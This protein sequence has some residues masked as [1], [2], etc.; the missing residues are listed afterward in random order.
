VSGVRRDAR[1]E[2]GEELARARSN[3]ELIV[4]Q[5]SMQ[6]ARLAYKISSG[7]PNYEPCGLIS[8]LRRAAVSAP[9]NIAESQGRLTDLQFR[10]F[11]GN[12][13][14]SLHVL[15]TQIKL[16][17][18][19]GFLAPGIVSEFLEQASEVARMI[20]GLIASMRK[21]KSP[22]SGTLTPLSARSAASSAQKELYS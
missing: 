21:M 7:L 8:Q 20:N 18:N 12:R 22:A 6:L 13:R 1:G 5:K 17:G 10:H 4:W 11:L 19:L 14:G 3:R 9:S 15:Q 16:A 2:R